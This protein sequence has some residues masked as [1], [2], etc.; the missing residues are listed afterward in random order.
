MKFLIIAGHGDGDPGAGVCGYW[1]ANL[2][3]E[4]LPLLAN[5]LKAYDG[6]DV[7]TYPTSRNAYADLKRGKPAYYFQDFGCVI[8]L[9]FNCYNGKAYGTE[10][11]YRTSKGL[12]TRVDRALA[13]AGD[14][15]D[16]G[17]KLRTDLQNMNIAY[18]YGVPYILIETCFIDHKADMRKYQEEKNAIWSAVAAAIAD[19]YDLKKVESR[20]TLTRA[21]WPETLKQGQRFVIKG[22]IRSAVR[23]KSVTF[24][25]EK[26]P[27]GEDVK[28]CTKKRYASSKAYDLSNLDPYIAFRKLKPGNYRYKVKAEDI[29]GTKVT[30][31]R[32]PFK[33]TKE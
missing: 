6:A 33:V 21:N 15:T 13:K 20:I 17:P 1:E 14:F 22:K 23:L 7:I 24:V 25:V 12:A 29:N 10:T 4:A 3:R 8:E 9:H 27:S 16:R 19:F 28:E 26:D 11:L 32:K 5:D 2:T 30:L 18:G 31:L